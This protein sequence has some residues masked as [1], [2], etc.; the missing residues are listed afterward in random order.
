[1]KL[2]KSEHAADVTQKVDNKWNRTQQCGR[3]AKWPK[4]FTSDHREQ[5]ERDCATGKN[6]NACREWVKFRVLRL[7]MRRH[8]RGQ[9]HHGQ[10]YDDAGKR[11]QRSPRIANLAFVVDMGQLSPLLVVLY[12]PTIPQRQAE[13]YDGGLHGSNVIRPKSSIIRAVY[14]HRR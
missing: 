12:P 2:P 9:E 13:D 10:D 5:A 4:Y 7:A 8:V 14:K 1:L 6:D 11:C 3:C